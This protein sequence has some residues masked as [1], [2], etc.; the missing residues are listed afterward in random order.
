VLAALNRSLTL[1]LQYRDAV[2]KAC[3]LSRR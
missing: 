3:G 2:A 1:W